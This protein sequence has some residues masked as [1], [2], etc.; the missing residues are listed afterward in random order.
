MD[1]L[2]GKVALV[3]GAAMGIGA[4]CVRR[5]LE[6]GARVALV[7]L[8][9]GP[10]QQLAAE[11]GDAAR[12]FHADVSVEAEVAAAVAAT[13]AAFGRLD[14]L[15]NNAG[16][17]GANKPTHELSEAE[18]DRV[19]AINVKGVFF[20][21]KHAIAPLRA[22]GGGSIVNLSSIYGLVGA[23]DSPPYHASKG[24][25]RLM[26]KTD[27]MLYAAD[28]IRVNSI[29]PGFI[30]TPMVEQHIASMGGD[31][32]Q[33]RRETGALHPLGHMGEP[34]DIAWGVVYL[35]S[36]ESKFVTGSELVI[37]GGY[38]CR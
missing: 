11:F 18:W 23:A 16:I 36:D 8:H 14:V 2:S 3:T 10:G 37:D 28:R 32:A 1:R 25:V 12:Y 6:A 7:D 22:A 30:W 24:A 29:H 20:C 27:A 34:D 5:L 9:D 26:S 4:A 15:V 13:V 38:T 31:P 33:H 19:Q 17:A 21:T 35:A